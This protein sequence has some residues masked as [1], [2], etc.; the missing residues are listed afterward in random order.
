M[1]CDAQMHEKTNKPCTWAYHL[2]NGWYLFT[3]PGNYCTHICHIKHMKSKQLSN[4][5]QFQHKCITNPSIMHTNK[6][7]QALEECIKTIQGMMGKDRNSQAAQ[8]LQRIV[9]TT[10]ACVQTNLHPYDETSTPDHISKMQQ[11]P[12]VQTPAST[13]IPHTTCKR[14]HQFQGCPETFLES[15]QS[16]RPTTQPAPDQATNPPH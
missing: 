15:N 6:V 10:Q 13:P 12:R 3:S 7:M 16:T 2:V 14:R 8:D 11:V 5:V 1:E 9:N 4:T